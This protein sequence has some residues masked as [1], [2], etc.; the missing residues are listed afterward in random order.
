MEGPKTLNFFFLTIERTKQ[1]GE[2]FHRIIISS[3]FMPVSASFH[4]GKNSSQLGYMV[5]TT[6]GH[7]QD[8]GVV[9]FQSP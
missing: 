5:V 4:S 9:L 3:H 8:I 7:G 6:S 2:T 1:A